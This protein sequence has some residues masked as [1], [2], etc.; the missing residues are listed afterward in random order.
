[1]GM[2][3][4]AQRYTSDAIDVTFDSNRCIHAAECVRGLP[5]VFD[6]HKRPWIQPGN[7]NADTVA[8][9]IE[10]CPT[11][12][13][14]FVRKDGGAG[15]ATPT[16]NTVQVCA[17]GPYYVRG[18]VHIITPEGAVVVEDVRMALCRCGQSQY[19]PFCDNAHLESGFQHDGQV[20]ANDTTLDSEGGELVITPRTNGPLKLQGNYIIV[21]AD[22]TSTNRGNAT[23]LCRCGGSHTKPF[24]DGTHK[25][26][27]FQA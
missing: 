5:V 24:C 26:I 23:A 22:G 14:H 6:T 21:S 10:R 1:M 16:Q 7:A 9:I 15:E 8:A 13:L 20:E 11:G 18:D 3:D 12:A 4:T 27:G 19:K 2:S 17:N 25:T